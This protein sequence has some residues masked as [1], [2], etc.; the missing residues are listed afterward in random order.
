MDFSSRLFF[1]KKAV[2][3]VLSKKLLTYNMRFTLLT[4]I[5]YNTVLLTVSTMYNRS[6]Q[7]FHLVRLKL[8]T[9]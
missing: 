2:T 9:H 7:L 1:K 6:I 3:T 8:C 5:V 4:I